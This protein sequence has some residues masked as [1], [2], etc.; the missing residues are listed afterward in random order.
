LLAID[1]PGHGRRGGDTIGTFE[2]EIRNLLRSLP[3]SIDEV[4]GYSFGGRIA[5]GLI[6]AAPER[7]RAATVISAHPGLTDPIL[8]DQRRVADRQWVRM[9]R[10][11]G[12]SAFV[13]AWEKLPL[14]DTQRRLAP[15]VLDRQR[16]RRL[17]QGAEG[18]ANCLERLGLAEMP[19][20]W[21]ALAR[22]PGRLRWI[23]GREDSK[24]LLIARQIAER[25]P[26]T[27]LLIID[28]VGHNPLIEA[29]DLLTRILFGSSPTG[30]AT[31][32]DMPFPV[33]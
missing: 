16:Q 28:D 29:P 17:S 14:F 24:F 6:L 15:A 32:G 30:R 23:V 31:A 21:D 19:S 18:L 2:D 33:T 9:L 27:D 22:F 1:L 8:R 20:T 13:R 3:P 5:L 7:F 4:V 25:R 12:I 26:A 11:Q 10:S